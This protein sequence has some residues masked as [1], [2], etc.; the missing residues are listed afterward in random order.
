VYIFERK[1]LTTIVKKRTFAFTGLGKAARSKLERMTQNMHF[2]MPAES[3]SG[4]VS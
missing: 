1:V 2:P 4:A 3:M